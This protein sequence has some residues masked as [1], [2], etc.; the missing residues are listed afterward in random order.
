MHTYLVL[1]RGVN[2]GGKNKV[3]MA[4]LRSCLEQ[5]GFS[6]VTTYIA[7]GNIFV[8]SDKSARTVAKTIEKALSKE[9]TLDS[10]IVRAHVLTK[11]QLQTVIEKKP[12]GFGDTPAMYHSDV[13]FLMDIAVDE[14]LKVFRPRKGV[15]NIWPG[16]GVIYSQRLSAERT[17]SRLS[18]IIGTPVY[19]SMTIRSWNSATKLLELF[20]SD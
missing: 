8:C 2:V 7:S 16:E 17:K 12:K 14:A 18:A 13:I 9:F 1:L 10:T 20:G 11:R 15:D 5:L 6:N 4:A 3:P 19:A